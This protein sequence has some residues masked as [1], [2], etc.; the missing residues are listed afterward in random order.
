MHKLIISYA[1]QTLNIFIPI[2]AIQLESKVVSLKCI[3]IHV[4]TAIS[5]KFRGGGT[6]R[7]WKGERLALRA[8]QT[9]QLVSRSAPR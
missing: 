7:E 8:L 9:P 6:V 4:R 2:E 5:K 3:K 1:T